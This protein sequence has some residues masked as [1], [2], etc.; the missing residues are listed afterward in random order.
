[1][2][3]IIIKNNSLFRLKKLQ[4]E[5]LFYENIFG[6]SFLLHWGEVKNPTVYFERN[7]NDIC[8]NCKNLERLE[9]Y[10]SYT[11]YCNY[12]EKW[13]I[14]PLKETCPFFEKSTCEKE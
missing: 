3:S 8:A 14:D 7:I 5:N 6:E 2:N 9:R 10:G 4:G 11:F 1:M 12:H 13:V